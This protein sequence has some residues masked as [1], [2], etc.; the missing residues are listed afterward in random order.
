VTR[1]TEE[2]VDADWLDAEADR[3]REAFDRDR[4]QFARDRQSE[5]RGLPR[6]E[7]LRLIE[8]QLALSSGSRA[9]NIEEAVSG[10]GPGSKPPPRQSE[11]F[12]GENERDTAR[13]LNLITAT[14]ERL[15]QLSDARTSRS[16]LISEDV[17]K[18]LV[19]HVGLS[20]GDVSALDPIFG[21]SEAVRSARRRLDL[22]PETGEPT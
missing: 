10:S 6:H 11:A 15:E 2:P 3:R 18:M 22:R 4:A 20:P 9:G 5:R 21:S 8:V 16:D 14:V 17:D 1:L 19:K 12:G 7:R 13:L